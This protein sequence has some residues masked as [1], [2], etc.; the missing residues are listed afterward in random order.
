[1][2]KL[3]ITSD[4][5]FL[6]Q[7]TSAVTLPAGSSKPV[8]DEQGYVYLSHGTCIRSMYSLTGPL[9]WE[10]CLPRNASGL[11]VPVLSDGNVYTVT[12]KGVVI[13]R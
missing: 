3:N 2:N 10:S 11:T 9:R 6:T 12:G 7:T 4:P 1:M 13:A 5:L 8:F